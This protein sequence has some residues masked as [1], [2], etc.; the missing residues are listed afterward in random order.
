MRRRA[1]AANKIRLMFEFITRFAISQHNK[2]LSPSDS[3]CQVT[4]FPLLLTQESEG[5]KALGFSGPVCQQ[6]PATTPGRHAHETLSGNLR[7][8]LIC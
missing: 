4:L 3:F 7:P 5:M 6:Q 2:A 1:F 8:N